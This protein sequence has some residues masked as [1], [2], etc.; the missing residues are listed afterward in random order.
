MR[1]EKNSQFTNLKN[2]G[3]LVIDV[4]SIRHSIILLFSDNE[5]S[6]CQRKQRRGCADPDRHLCFLFFFCV[7]V[8]HYSLSFLLLITTPLVLSLFIT[9]T[10]LLDCYYQSPVLCSSSSSFSS[11]YSIDSWVSFTHHSPPYYGT[12]DSIQLLLRGISLIPQ[13]I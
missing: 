9:L 7:R 1:K 13:K 6:Y 12:W 2:V 3:L 8:H 11:F 4:V 10:L 5:F